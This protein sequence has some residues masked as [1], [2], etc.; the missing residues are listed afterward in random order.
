MDSPEERPWGRAIG[1]LAACIITLV[2]AMNWL[3]PD[4]ILKRALFAGALIGITV[5]GFLVVCES[6]RAQS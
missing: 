2:G 1:L 6:V 4:V 5:R 3:D